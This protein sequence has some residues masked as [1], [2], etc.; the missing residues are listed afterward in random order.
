MNY[1]EDKESCFYEMLTSEYLIPCFNISL[2]N[3]IDINDKNA[4]VASTIFDNYDFKLPFQYKLTDEQFK[5]YNENKHDVIDELVFYKFDVDTCKYWV[6]TY[7]IFKIIKK[8]LTNY[9]TE[10]MERIYKD[11][12]DDQLYCYYAYYILLEYFDNIVYQSNN[13]ETTSTEE[14]MI[15]LE[16][17][18]KK[19]EQ[20]YKHLHP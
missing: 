4:L 3:N 19:I 15:E 7:G 2:N 8:V 1:C 16:K 13:K 17:E 18:H 11:K 6:E 14:D 9:S 10:N 5:L 12:N 20:Y